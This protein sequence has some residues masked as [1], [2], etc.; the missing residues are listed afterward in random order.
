MLDEQELR[1]DIF[2]PIA[3]K[4]LVSVQHY[5]IFAVKFQNLNIM[6]SFWCICS[7]L[8]PTCSSIW[9]GFGSAFGSI[10]MTPIRCSKIISSI[11]VVFLVDGIA[12]SFLAT[13]SIRSDFLLLQGLGATSW[14]RMAIILISLFL[15]RR[16]YIVSNATL[17]DKGMVCRI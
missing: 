17:V 12:N 3:T 5:W 14:Q 1:T 6:W 15:S 8:I 10:C 13:Y 16:S 9:G 11:S 4:L 2:S 7:V